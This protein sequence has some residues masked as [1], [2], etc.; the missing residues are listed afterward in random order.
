MAPQESARHGGG[1]H[2]EPDSTG[3]QGERLLDILGYR[4]PGHTRKGMLLAQPMT[5]AHLPSG[6]HLFTPS[7][8]VWWL[9]FYLLSSTRPFF[10]SRC[11]QDP[12]FLYLY[13]YCD[14]KYGFLSVTI[15]ILTKQ[16]LS[17]LSRRSFLAKLAH[18]SSSS[19]IQTVLPKLFTALP[20]V[21]L[22]QQVA[23]LC[24]HIHLPC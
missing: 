10:L 17:S 2:Q 11:C 1:G 19:T 20:T 18:G 12:F 13:Q 14:S 21:H 24:H 15:Q 4:P 7:F 16:S 6:L 5:K 3:S 9:A 8:G 22:S 23:H